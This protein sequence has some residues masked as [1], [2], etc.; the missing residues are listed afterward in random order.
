MDY[1]SLML[2]WLLGLLSPG[3]T[4]R[5][6]RKYRSKELRQSLIAEMRDLR[7]RMANVA[8][9]VSENQGLVTDELLDW[10]LPTLRSYDGPLASTEYVDAVAKTR[11]IPA[12][13]AP[14]GHLELYGGYGLHLKEY[15]LPLSQ[16]DERRTVHLSH[17]VSRESASLYR[18]AS[19]VQSAGQ[20]LDR[21][22]GPNF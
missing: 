11:E 5:I 12:R 2:G 7:Y 4:E 20:Y 6:R 15:S 19:V 1:L 17:A 13:G 3:I 16:G 21:F 14:K 8:H 10:L 9:R 18:R 22:V